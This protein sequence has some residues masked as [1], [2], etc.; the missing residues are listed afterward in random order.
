MRISPITSDQWLKVFKA[1]A[2]SFVSAAIAGLM[3]TNYD[4]SKK[5]LVAVLV[6]GINGAMV[7]IKQLFT[8]PS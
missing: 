1:V 5:T 2:Y 6:A 8:T 7:A 4:L 3:A